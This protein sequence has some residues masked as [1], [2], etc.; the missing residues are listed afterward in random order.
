MERT[1]LGS[2]G[3]FTRAGFAFALEIGHPACT[4]RHGAP[5]IN[6]RWPTSKSGR[7]TPQASRAR[8]QREA[9]PIDVHSATQKR[10]SR[11]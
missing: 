3:H 9:E 11:P 8:I 2:G 6:D 5:H 7:M 10:F 4:R 1:G